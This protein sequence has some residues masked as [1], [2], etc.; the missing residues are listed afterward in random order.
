MPDTKCLLNRFSEATKG[1]WS[2]AAVIEK[3]GIVEKQL[4]VL[5]MARKKMGV[6]AALDCLKN[7]DV[8][9]MEIDLILCIGEEWKEYPLTT[10]GIY[11]QEKSEPIMPGQLTFSNVAEQR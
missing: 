5:M 10:S 1:V 6:R 3:L 8:D 7:T 9:P 4:P 2:E 11:I